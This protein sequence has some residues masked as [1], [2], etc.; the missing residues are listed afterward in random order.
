MIY[1]FPL[2]QYHGINSEISWVHIMLSDAVVY[3]RLVHY[4]LLYLQSSWDVSLWMQTIVRHDLVQQL[5]GVS[6]DLLMQEGVLVK[7]KFTWLDDMRC[8]GTLH[9]AT[10]RILLR[11]ELEK[12]VDDD[13]LVREVVGT[14]REE[15]IVLTLLQ[16]FEIC[17]PTLTKSPI[18][19]EAPEFIPG[20]KRW[21]SAS[22]VKRDPDGACLF[23]MYLKDN[24][25]V[26][27]KWGQD[28]QDD[29]AV[30]V[31]FLPEIPHG[32]FHR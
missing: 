6:R 30:H 31:Y 28:K 14:K 10:I 21:E 8:R 7:Q 29:I 20:K 1:L 11:R 16:Y 2:S 17:L 23:P 24:L 4:L 19:P 32:F 5:E 15:G 26:S 22:E 9:N 13:D 3:I 12:L 27:H 18:N 25:I